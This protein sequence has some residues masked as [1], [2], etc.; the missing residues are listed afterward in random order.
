MKRK[1]LI[2]EDDKWFADS[3]RASLKQKFSVR[4]CHNPEKIFEMLDKWWPDIL[5]A[6]VILGEKNLFTLLNE[7]QSYTD[8]RELAVVILSSAARQI[9]ISDVAQYNVQKVLDK[10]KI[11]PAELRQELEL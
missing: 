3:L 10:A 6:D 11:T 8:T 4:V 9:K 2:L 1:I 5:L 7:I